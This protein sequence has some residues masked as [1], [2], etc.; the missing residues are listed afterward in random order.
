VVAGVAGG[1]VAWRR[2]TKWGRAAGT[3]DPVAAGR[4]NVR[5]LEEPTRAA[6]ATPTALRPD[7]RPQG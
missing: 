7:R 6:S 1:R 3:A 4:M 2:P 5:P